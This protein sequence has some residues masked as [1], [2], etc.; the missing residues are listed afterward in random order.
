MRTVTRSGRNY[1]P[2]K[3]HFEEGDI[4]WSV[5]QYGYPFRVKIVEVEDFSKGGTIEGGYVYYWFHPLRQ[6]PKW[7]KL[8]YDLKWRTWDWFKWRFLRQPIFPPPWY[9]PGHAEMAGEVL[10]HCPLDAIVE[11]HASYAMHHQRSA[12][13]FMK[14]DPDEYLQECIERDERDERDL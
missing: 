2:T 4:A 8:L 12:E 6:P 9:G 7:I 13:Y 11:Y 1:D 3:R 5:D 10:F 14:K